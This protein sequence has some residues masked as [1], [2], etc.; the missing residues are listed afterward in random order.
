M[1]IKFLCS[2]K[3]CRA[4]LTVG[5]ELAGK[6]V[7]CPRCKT[8]MV[9]PE[10]EPVISD[11]RPEPSGER[12]RAEAGGV[13]ELDAF[14]DE[15]RGRRAPFDVEKE[16]ARG[17]M[18]AVILA[19]DKAL[20]REVAV[21][22]MRPQI[23]D[24]EEHRLRF[25]DEAQITAQLEHPNIV[26][27]HELGKNAQ[28]DLYVTMKL[29]KGKS[30]GEILAEL[31]TLDVRPE[32][33]DRS[34]KAKAA[35]R[36]GAKAQRAD[37]KAEA[38]SPGNAGILPASGRSSGLQAGVHSAEA[39]DHAGLESSATTM[40]LSDLLS[41]FLKIC[42]GMAFAHAKGVIH[43]DLKPD[44]IMVGEFGEVQIMDW[45]LAKV[46]GDKGQGTRDGG[47]EEEEERGQDLSHQSSVTR[48]ESEIRSPKS[49]IQDESAIRKADTVRSVR[50]DSDVALTVDGQI[51]GT[52][53]YMPP[54]Q[55]EGKLELIDHRSDVYSLGAILY[56]ILTLE[57]PIEGDTVHKVLLNVSDGNV[58]PP[59]QRT[60]GRHVPKELSAVVMKAMATNRRKRYQSVQD[61]GQDIRL[62]LE[63]R[64]VSAKED[65]FVEAFTKLMKRNKGVSVTAAAAAVVLAIGLG[66][67]FVKI[68]AE[69]NEAIAQKLA[70]EDARREQHET[71][72]KASMQLALQAAR[73]AEIGRMGEARIRAD[74]AAQMAPD[75]PWGHY[76]R[77]KLAMAE[78]N[79]EIAERELRKAVEITPD[80]ERCK[81]ALAQLLA[82]S[83]NLEAAAAL[84]A[85]DAKTGDW[86]AL[87]RAGD[88]LY[89]AERYR[90]AEKAYT[91][92]IDQFG[93]SQRVRERERDW[94]LLIEKA[95]AF[96]AGELFPDAK[97]AYEKALVLAEADATAPP[98]LPLATR[99]KL[100]EVE[101]GLSDLRGTL[102][103]AKG[104][105][106]AWVQCEGFHDAI[107]SLPAEE[108][109]QRIEAKLQELHG[110][111]V[112]T[113]SDIR[114]GVLRR[115]RVTNEIEYL[116]P[117]KGVPVETLF[118]R[119]AR[120]S[121]LSA[122]RGAPLR[123]LDLADNRHI[124]D[125]SPLRGM[126]L[127]E[128]NLQ[129]AT[130]VSDLSPLEGMALKK[131][132]LVCCRQ[133][134][135]L[136]PLK[137]MPLVEF[138]CSGGGIKDLSALR[139]M[140]LERLVCHGT[141]VDDLSPLEGA[142]LAELTCTYCPISDLGPLEGMPLRALDCLGTRV[143][144]LALLRGM[145]L[146]QLGCGQTLVTD[147]GPLKGMPLEKLNCGST[148]VRD[149]SPLAGMPLR[150]LVCNHT[151][152]RDLAPLAGM[153]LTFLDCRS[154]KVR[155]LGPLKGMPLSSLHLS[156]TQVADLSPLKGAP[157]KSL[158]IEETD[159]TD[160]TPL[161]GMG[162]EQLSLTP[163]KIRNGMDAIRGMK[164]LKSIGDLFGARSF[165]PAEFWKKYDAGEFR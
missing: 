143:R 23:A 157:L 7:K 22:V 59:E 119:R 147:L 5:D 45:G 160:L 109:F 72:L 29:V 142:P 73:A 146:C 139:G 69:R 37:K 149:L 122:L 129:W 33:R 151:D 8:V 131:L 136:G 153:P 66:G 17:G 100:E 134:H 34:G 124:A 102:G 80:D 60:P 137:G 36:K 74:A 161:E 71:A 98:E 35:S 152:V 10:A 150:W 65:T 25:L 31:K 62:F 16:I 115:V 49:A 121:D 76:A 117:L 56:E 32:T 28:G 105:A 53:A 125:L 123:S 116:Q 90:E 81:A 85:G 41:I 165:G 50:T 154:T 75:G 26:P 130:L 158:I 88:A 103:R 77:G 118:A 93:V 106:W 84:V 38:G 111:S 133:V 86:H 112:A 155:D 101:R 55:A 99:K 3:D 162:L 27:V 128:L 127:E 4:E 9:V 144:D 114:D 135:D 46:V 47:P 120:L 63:G 126:P 97:I 107:K 30:L 13:E 52:P 132:N 61:L 18:G 164:S 108:Q 92:A 138:H 68:T 51:T 64:S 83:G 42:D 79:L 2:N 15:K 159:V 54:E 87:R 48:P 141:D 39:Q 40:S 82:M 44:N 89:A 96:L 94:R 78:K 70:A 11:Q 140:P 6:K 20:Q 67:A 58:T 24:S 145:A 148:R 57:R 14:L 21:K 19:R 104:N 95:D 156:G 43:R 91:R 163:S 113:G 110:K 12:E 1:A